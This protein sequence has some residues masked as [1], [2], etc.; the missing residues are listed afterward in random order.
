MTNFFKAGITLPSCRAQLAGESFSFLPQR[1]V[2]MSMNSP[3][4]QPEVSQ[5]DRAVTELTTKNNEVDFNRLSKN[6]QK[7]ITNLHK[8]IKKM[9]LRNFYGVNESKKVASMIKTTQ[10]MTIAIDD[11]CNC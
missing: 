5:F 3:S 10:L 11:Y 4:T 1:S 7:A 9:D 6:A 8:F 2:G